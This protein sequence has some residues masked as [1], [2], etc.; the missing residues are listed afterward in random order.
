MVAK[1][2]YNNFI[3]RITFEVVN[4]A[5]EVLKAVLRDETGSI[6]S[7]FEAECEKPQNTL[8]WEGLNELP[9]GVYTLEISGGEEALAFRC[10]KRI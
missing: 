4:Q 9:Y 5:S 1:L 6:C 2:R 8:N 3:D 7:K 10:V